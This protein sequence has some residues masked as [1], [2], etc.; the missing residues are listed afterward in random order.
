MIFGYLDRRSH[1]VTS[2][3]GTG[4]QGLYGNGTTGSNDEITPAYSNSVSTRK[5]LTTF[6]ERSVLPSFRAMIMHRITRVKGF[7]QAR[8]TT[9]SVVRTWRKKR[10]WLTSLG[11]YQESLAS[12][13]RTRLREGWP[14][15]VSTHVSWFFSWHY[16]VITKYR[17]RTRRWRPLGLP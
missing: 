10:S 17:M 16:P 13:S 9:G 11:I 3:F 7:Y 8:Q 4:S 1:T 2:T 14:V 12:W 6:S 15:I 5:S